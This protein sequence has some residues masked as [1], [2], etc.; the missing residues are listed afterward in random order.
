MDRT[1]RI[2]LVLAL[3][4][5]CTSGQSAYAPAS[6]Q[7]PPTEEARRTP[8]RSSD[9]ALGRPERPAQLMRVVLGE[10]PVLLG[11][12]RAIILDGRTFALRDAPG[13][14]E[15]IAC[16]TA[17]PHSRELVV[18]LR[19]G[20]FAMSDGRRIPI[21]TTVSLA[22]R[23]TERCE[24]LLHP[25]VFTQSGAIWYH[26]EGAF[27]SLEWTSST[28]QRLP[29]GDECADRNL[30]MITP[31]GGYTVYSTDGGIAVRRVRDNGVAFTA[32]GAWRALTDATERY[33]LVT[34]HAGGSQR[35]RVVELASGTTVH[36]ESNSIGVALREQ[37]KQLVALHDNHDLA[38][39]PYFT[40]DWQ[41]DRRRVLR[42]SVDAVWADA[43]PIVSDDGSGNAFVHYPDGNT[44]GLP[45][46]SPDADVVTWSVSPTGELAA[47]SERVFELMEGREASIRVPRAPLA[48]S[49]WLGDQSLVALRRTQGGIL[50]ASVLELTRPL[51]AQ[52][53][54]ET[55]VGGIREY[56]TAN[57]LAWL[58]PADAGQVLLVYDAA[59][60][61][62]LAVGG[63]LPA[64]L[65]LLTKDG[66]YC[67]DPRAARTMADLLGWARPT[68]R[69]PEGL[70]AWS[71]CSE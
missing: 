35:T 2:A 32:P 66:G 61:S 39:G 17:L 34:E 21:M 40:V 16:V 53:V 37:G 71:L 11:T 20:E 60:R 69:R 42:P 56:A 45:R 28:T 24:E 12:G 8:G 15:S 5:A 43:G 59:M 58:R 49:K 50:E 18:L 22:D 7:A 1:T 36:V 44:Y 19:S 9:T 29:C 47:S 6:T 62:L 30:L 48:G 57:E 13:N 46:A 63:A 54:T 68:L 25:A 64:E 65:A 23:Q 67:G 31:R 70:K 38:P 51:G 3:T 10:R 14:G 33:L 26:N 27:T 4:S 55:V 41:H 52:R